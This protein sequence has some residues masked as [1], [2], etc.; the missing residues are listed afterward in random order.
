MYLLLEG[1]QTKVDMPK[2]NI[3]N[4]FDTYILSGMWLGVYLR[5]NTKKTNYLEEIEHVLNI[6]QS[7]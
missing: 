6:M 2:S 1:R 3:K 5:T 7:F 4:N